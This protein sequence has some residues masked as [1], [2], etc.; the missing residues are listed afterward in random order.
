VASLNDIGDV[1]APEKNERFTRH[2]LGVPT[3]LQPTPLCVANSDRHQHNDG[4]NP[5]HRA[6]RGRALDQ[7]SINREHSSLQT[8]QT[9]LGITLDLSDAPADHLGLKVKVQS[10]SSGAV[11]AGFRA[12]GWNYPAKV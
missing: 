6:C 8:T 10:H 2:S 3:P 12:M 7:I 4:E 1:G 11:S 5:A 9:Y